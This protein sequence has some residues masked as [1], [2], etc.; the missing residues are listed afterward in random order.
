MADKRL[1]ELAV[2]ELQTLIEALEDHTEGVLCDRTVYTG[3][4]IVLAQKLWSLRDK[5]ASLLY[6]YDGES[7]GEST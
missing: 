3:T 2:D 6:D 5:L 7:A 1:I 4:K